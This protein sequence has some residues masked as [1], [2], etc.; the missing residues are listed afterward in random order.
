[1]SKL[2]KIVLSIAFSTAIASSLGG[3]VATGS[4]RDFLS[5]A[6]NPLGIKG[7]FTSKKMYVN[8]QWSKVY[9]YDN[10]EQEVQ[11]LYGDPEEPLGTIFIDPSKITEAK[12]DR[13]IN[14]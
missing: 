8:G 9:T 3:C 11:P 14:K 4:P 12:G 6:V 10:G 2:E 1:M 13:T 5:F 7:H